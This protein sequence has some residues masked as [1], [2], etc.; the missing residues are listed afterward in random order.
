MGFRENE[1]KGTITN[2]NQVLA[3]VVLIFLDCEGTAER[4]CQTTSYG[5]ALSLVLDTE[6]LRTQRA[7]CRC[8]L[9]KI[10][11]LAI[12]DAIVVVCAASPHRTA[13]I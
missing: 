6:T 9:A 7:Y 13:K 1:V 11:A 3:L 8:N 4:I 2:K 12:R 10:T 5:V